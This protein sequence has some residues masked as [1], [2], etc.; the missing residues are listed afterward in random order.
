MT[1]FE[2]LVQI[3]S[4]FRAT[5]ITLWSKRFSCNVRS[6]SKYCIQETFSQFWA[7]YAENL[8]VFKWLISDKNNW[9]RMLY[10]SFQSTTGWSRD[11]LP[12]SV[13]SNE[14]C[15]SCWNK[16]KI[17]II[18][19]ELVL[20]SVGSAIRTW[21]IWLI[22]WFIRLWRPGGKPF[23]QALWSTLP[24]DLVV[25]QIMHPLS[26]EVGSKVLNKVV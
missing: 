1:F 3:H 6:N 16:N 4:L 10:F 26:S 14:N 20:L 7:V 21:P 12:L 23:R 9:W 5:S 25:D 18:R 11:R 24:V 15:T 13:Y 17:P 8:S 19:T 22:D 2:L